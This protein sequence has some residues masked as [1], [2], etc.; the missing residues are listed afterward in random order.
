MIYSSIAKLS[1]EEITSLCSE[2]RRHNCI[3]AEL[4]EQ[5]GVKR[6][7]RNPDGTG[8]L[9]G[10]TSICDVVGYQRKDDQII[11]ID[12]RLIY[13]S[14]DLQD[15]VDEAINNDR[16]MFEEVA[17]LL[18]FGCRANAE[19]LAKFRHL[20]EEHRELPEGAK[21]FPASIQN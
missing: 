18:L 9:A 12:G 6:G 10:L 4:S 11:P 16:F 19:Q 5:Y 21:H 13:R 15:L 8:V 17:W 3:N 14:I 2:Y 1:E 7:L 20:M